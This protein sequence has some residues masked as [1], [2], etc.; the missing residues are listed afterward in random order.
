[1]THQKGLGDHS[2]K[3]MRQTWPNAPPVPA[4]RTTTPTP[5][6]VFAHAW[7]ERPTL[8]WCRAPARGLERGEEVERSGRQFSMGVLD[9]HSNG[10][11]R[12]L[13]LETHSQ[14]PMLGL[15]GLL[16]FVSSR[17]ASSSPA[18]ICR[19]PEG[20]MVIGKPQGVGDPYGNPSMVGHVWSGMSCR[21]PVFATPRAYFARRTEYDAC[22]CRTR[23]HAVT[24]LFLW[25]ST[26]CDHLPKCFFFG[27]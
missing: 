13:W 27:C 1:M 15:L 7:W 21:F 26:N 19:P 24:C 17:S 11:L 12:Q 18:R 16:G 14:E 9:G 25:T 23:G 10:L 8:W 5:A 22:L 6:P 3:P 2:A 4:L 20:P